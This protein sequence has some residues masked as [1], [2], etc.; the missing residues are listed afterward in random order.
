MTTT[1]TT[2]D[3]RTYEAIVKVHL[4]GYQKPTEVKMQVKACGLP[5]ATENIIAAWYK[6]TEPK[7]IS[8]K[9][10]EDKLGKSGKI[11]EA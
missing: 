10:I 2:E 1:P 9:E 3:E 11:Q 7:D 5:Q 6:A 8:V 4:P